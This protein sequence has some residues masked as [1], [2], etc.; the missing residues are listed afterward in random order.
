LPALPAG[1]LDRGC[2][3]YLGVVAETES[4]ISRIVVD[5][6]ILAVGFKKSQKAWRL[7]RTRSQPRTTTPEHNAV[8]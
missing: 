6:F 4:V 8:E 7:A 1:E 5:V 3:G 2:V